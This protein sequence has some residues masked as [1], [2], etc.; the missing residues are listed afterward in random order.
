MFHEKHSRT[1]AK[2]ITWRL[3]A[4]VSSVL[5]L[6][7]LIGD[8]ES[9]IYHSVII[10]SVKTVLYYVHERMWNSSNFGQELRS[11]KAT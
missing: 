9:S 4:F 5:V 3:V 2:S 1:I 7:V 10:H 6:Y 11:S 8:W